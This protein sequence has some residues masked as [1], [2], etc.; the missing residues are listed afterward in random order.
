MGAFGD[1]VDQVPGGHTDLV[2]MGECLA[3][4]CSVL[5]SLITLVAGGTDA[6][7]DQIDDD[8]VVDGGDADAVAWF[9]GDTAIAERDLDVP[10]L[11]GGWHRRAPS[12]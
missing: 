4:E 2:V 1:V 9:V 6:L 5:R 12:W 11:L 3:Q 7:E 10:H 8:R